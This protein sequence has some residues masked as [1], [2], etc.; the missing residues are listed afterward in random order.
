M[1][2]T[3]PSIL[4]K[5]LAGLFQQISRNRGVKLNRNFQYAVYG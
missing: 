3:D 2:N 4:G 1:N 5:S